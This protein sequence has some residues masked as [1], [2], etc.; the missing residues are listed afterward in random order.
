MLLFSANY[1]NNNLIKKIA[2]ERD[3]ND[4]LIN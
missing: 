4:D 3:I 1:K 2:I